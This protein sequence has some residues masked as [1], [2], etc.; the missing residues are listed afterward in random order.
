MSRLTSTNQQLLTVTGLTPT[1]NYTLI[2]DTVTVGTYTGAALT[3]GINIATNPNNPDLIQANS[4]NQWYANE[5][6]YPANSSYGF[7]YYQWNLDSDADLTYALQP[8]PDSILGAL[9]RLRSG[10]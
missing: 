1:T 5:S 3:S 7:W 10:R 9:G 2:I 8:K 4:V 6:D